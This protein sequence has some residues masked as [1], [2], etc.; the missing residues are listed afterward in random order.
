MVDKEE[1][2]IKWATKRYGE[3]GKPYFG[4]VDISIHNTGG[5]KLNYNQFIEHIKKHRTTLARRR[6][7]KD[8][9][10]NWG[11]YIV[12]EIEYLYS[13]KN[14]TYWIL[15]DGQYI[16]SLSLH[17]NIDFSKT[18]VDDIVFDLVRMQKEERGFI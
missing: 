10:S 17:E 5:Y 13:G 15:I 1:K 7:K 8:I 18:E 9:Y 6:V 14:I 2:L 4:K 3:E 11:I 12:K 16:V